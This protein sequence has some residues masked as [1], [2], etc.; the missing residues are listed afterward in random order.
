MCVYV[1]NVF[2]HLLVIDTTWILSQIICTKECLLNIATTVPKSHN[3]SREPRFS[4]TLLNAENYSLLH[5]ECFGSFPKFRDWITFT[6]TSDHVKQLD[7]Q[8]R[9]CTCVDYFSEEMRD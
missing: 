2:M 6:G 9:V 4:R 3:R 1:Y 5:V 8:V 7:L